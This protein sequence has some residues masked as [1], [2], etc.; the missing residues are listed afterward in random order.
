MAKEHF[1]TGSHWTGAWVGL[2]TKARFEQLPVSGWKRT[3]K[4][5]MYYCP[6]ENGEICE[7]NVIDPAT[8]LLFVYSLTLK[9]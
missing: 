2:W 3:V 1:Y 9:N 5:S 7:Q 8:V 4:C 6:Q